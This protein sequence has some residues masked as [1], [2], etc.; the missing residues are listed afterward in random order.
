MYGGARRRRGGR[1]GNFGMVRDE[2]ERGE[3][4]AP[5]T[6][7]GSP[8]RWSSTRPSTRGNPPYDPAWDAGGA[9]A[10][11]FPSAGAGE[12]DYRVRGA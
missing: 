5:T 7:E 10:D 6:G 11:Q 8:K 4:A 2:H 1:D 3:A 12:E 9:S